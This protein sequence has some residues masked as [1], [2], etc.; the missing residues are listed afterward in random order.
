MTPLSEVANNLGVM[1]SRRGDYTKALE[2]FSRAYQGDS[3]D[4]DFCLNLGVSLWYLKRYD[5]A[6]PYLEHA[7]RLNDEDPAAH[8]LLAAVFDKLGNAK[9]EKRQLD[10]LGQHDGSSMATVEEDILPQARLKKN[11][12]GFRLRPVAVAKAR[13]EKSK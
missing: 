5:E 3:K 12:P 4:F 1:E 6:A 10:W 8:A 2:H 11:F 7:T 13:E 9:G